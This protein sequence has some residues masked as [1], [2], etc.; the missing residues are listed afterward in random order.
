VLGGLA[1]LGMGL[2]AQLDGGRLSVSALGG[3]GAPDIALFAPGQLTAL[4]AA[5]PTAAAR[6][7]VLRMAAALPALP[8]SAELHD[9]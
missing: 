6:C 8:A 5:A 7:D 9:W 4:A 1:E 2:G 3:G